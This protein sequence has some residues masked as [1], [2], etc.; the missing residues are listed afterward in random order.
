MGILFLIFDLEIA[1]L[2]PAAVSLYQVS[3]YGFAI[4]LVFLVV[5]TV[6]FVYELAKGALK[7]TDHRSAVSRVD[8]INEPSSSPLAAPLPSPK[9]ST[10]IQNRPGFK[11][12]RERIRV[13]K[14]RSMLHR[15]IATSSF[16]VQ[17]LSAVP[18]L[19]PT[20]SLPFTQEAKRVF[21][22]ANLKPVSE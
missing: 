16:P 18:H 5:L 7:F 10:S 11:Q 3:V 8:V 9:P 22:L 13:R 19:D 21:I 6:G 17:F 15:G 1:V 14:L 20:T 12:H 4:V 2:F